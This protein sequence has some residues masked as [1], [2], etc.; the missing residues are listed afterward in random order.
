MKALVTALACVLGAVALISPSSADDNKRRIWK[1]QVFSAGAMIPAG[2]T[3]AVLAEIAGGRKFLLTQYCQTGG[4]FGP[5][6]VGSSFG[7][8]AKKYGNCTEYTP[9]VLLKGG[10]T[11]SCVSPYEGVYEDTACLITG[12]LR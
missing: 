6:L 11:L 8:V 1:G 9:G 12:Y 4:D 3:A 5:Q 10:Q 7:V 2:G